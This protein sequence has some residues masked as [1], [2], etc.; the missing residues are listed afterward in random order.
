MAARVTGVV[1]PSGDAYDLVLT[2]TLSSSV[3]E[4]W[5][6]VT[7]PAGLAP[8]IGTFSG[9]PAS[10]WV[11]F[12]MGFEEAAPDALESR[13]QILSCRERELLRI[14][15]EQPEGL[16]WLVE[17]A[18]TPATTPESA[19]GS[20]LRLTHRGLPATATDAVGPGWEY[21]LD[22]LEA[23]VAG[24]DLSLVGPEQFE[25]DYYPALSADYRV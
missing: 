20:E 4:V 10:G 16:P 14:A 2:R 1:E 24:E 5:A 23:S 3:A 22:R 15:I 17:L 18:L 21:Y 7:T 25:R 8:W 13:V 6:A 19:G 9:D 12:T 11:T